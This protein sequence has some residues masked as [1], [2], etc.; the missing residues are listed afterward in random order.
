MAATPEAGVPEDEVT[1]AATTFG[2]AAREKVEAWGPGIAAAT[3]E[4]S[5]KKG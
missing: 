1:V 4:R 5:L 2:V 3:G